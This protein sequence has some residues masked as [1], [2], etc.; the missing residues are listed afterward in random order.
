MWVD[1]V[2]IIKLKANKTDGPDRLKHAKSFNALYG[3]FCNCQVAFERCKISTPAAGIIDLVY[4]IDS[5]IFSIKNLNSQLELFEPILEQALDDYFL[6]RE[7]TG[8]FKPREIIRTQLKILRKIVHN[9]MEVM[10]QPLDEFGGFS[11]AIRELGIFI[12]RTYSPD[13]IFYG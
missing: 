10:D 2:N 13:E 4:A 12:A 3:T 9:E 1:L 8:M 5:L 11:E 7:Q 6:M